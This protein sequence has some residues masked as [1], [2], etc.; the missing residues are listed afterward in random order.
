MLQKAYVF[1]P[2]SDFGENSLSTFRQDYW[3]NSNCT[4]Q[5]QENLLSLKESKGTGSLA[6]A[7]FLCCASEKKK[8]KPNFSSQKT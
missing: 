8:G 1:S 6:R 2:N 3:F 4:G 5:T 7:D